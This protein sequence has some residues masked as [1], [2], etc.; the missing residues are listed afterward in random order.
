[1]AYQRRVLLGGHRNDVSG[2]SDGVDDVLKCCNCRRCFV[3]G[4]TS[5]VFDLGLSLVE[6]GNL[7]LGKK[8]CCINRHE[9]QAGTFVMLC[10]ECRNYLTSDSRGNAW[11]SIWPSYM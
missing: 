10:S 1:M 2:H 4:E 9:V 3:D 8:Y 5:A 7:G 11:K 6:T